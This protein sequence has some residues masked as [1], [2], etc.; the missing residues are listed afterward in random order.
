MFTNRQTWEKIL[1][2][3]W[4]LGGKNGGVLM[5]LR[6]KGTMA[7]SGNEKCLPRAEGD[8]LSRASREYR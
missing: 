5:Y 3:R 6:K 2:V 8:Y 4:K 1:I 7:G